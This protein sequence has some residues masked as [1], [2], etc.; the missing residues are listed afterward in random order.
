MARF[1]VRLVDIQKN[2]DLSAVL[3]K[4]YGAMISHQ[5]QKKEIAVPEGE[6]KKYVFVKKSDPGHERLITTMLFDLPK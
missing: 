3:A 4:M 5:Y 1:K 2:K 6:D